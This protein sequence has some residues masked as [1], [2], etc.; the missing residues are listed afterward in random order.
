MLTEQL[1]EKF[2]LYRENGILCRI[3]DR[4]KILLA[5]GYIRSITKSQ[6]QSNLLRGLRVVA[7]KAL[8]ITLEY[9]GEEIVLYLDG[10][11]IIVVAE[12][13]GEMKHE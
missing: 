7:L 8:L 10:T 4:D 1:I 5:R 13:R 2:D 12:M 3:Y 6:V 11:E 9:E